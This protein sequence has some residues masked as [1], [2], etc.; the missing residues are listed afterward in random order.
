MGFPLGRNWLGTCRLPLTETISEVYE[1]C[2]FLDK[3]DITYEPMKVALK[4]HL[5][6]RTLL[7][8]DVLSKCFLFCV[9]RHTRKL[10]CLKLALKEALSTRE[11]RR[12]W[13]GPRSVN[14]RGRKC[15]PLLSF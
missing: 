1:L 9:L 13:P 15:G 11:G 5:E 4:T 14:E 7:P 10:L 8:V 12:G 2:A 6:P 3:R